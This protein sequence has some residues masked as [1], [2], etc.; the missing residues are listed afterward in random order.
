ML[1]ISATLL[2]YIKKAVIHYD[3]GIVIFLS[4]RVAAKH[5]DYPNK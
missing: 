1:W 2:Y 3:N 5:T 4:M